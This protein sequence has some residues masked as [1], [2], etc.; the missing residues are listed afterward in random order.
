MAGIQETKDVIKTA[1]QIGNGIGIALQDG[2]FELTELVEFVPALLSLPTALSGITDVPLE[3]SDLDE[4]ERRELLDYMRQEF[5][6]PQE[7]TEEA[8][9]DHAE[10]LL[11]LWKLVDKYYL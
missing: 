6:I 1:A 5:D 10:F 2:K 9:E 8:V 11:A 7:Q 3:L 4:A